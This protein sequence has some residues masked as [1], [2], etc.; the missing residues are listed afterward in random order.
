[1]AKRKK[2]YIIAEVGINHN[3]SLDNCY[4]LIDAA[5]NAGCDCVKFQFFKAERL[6]PRSSGKLAWKDKEKK[7]N[8]DIYSAVESFELPTHWIKRLMRYCRNKKIDFLSS[9]FDREDAR[10][11]M[12]LGMNAI[13]ISSYSVTNLPLIE[14]CARYK[15]PIVMST[16]GATLGEIEDA[17]SVVNRYHDK[18]S[19]L[20]CT[21]KYPTE[22]NECN[23]GVIETLRYAFPNNTIGYSDHTQEIFA[24]PIQAVY[25]GA[26]II[27]KHVTLDKKMKGPDHFFALE[28][29]ELKK[30]IR[31]IR[32]AELNYQQRNFKINKLIHGN[33][34]KIIYPQEGYLRNFAFMKLFAKRDIK[35]RKIIR[36]VDIAIL[37]PGGKEQGLDPKYLKLFKDYKITAKRNI[38]FEEPITWDLFLP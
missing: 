34:A 21:L 10:Y 37:R 24:A 5:V 33:T 17:V 35:K 14:Y 12:R 8:Y 7:Y 32:L 31:K 11:L 26:K 22:L 15:L 4:K 13:K 27:E 3:G 29:V 19:L 18:L 25:L 16:G 28:P 6:Y 20:H 36:P 9:V 30:M 2:V 23:L 38:V 1:M